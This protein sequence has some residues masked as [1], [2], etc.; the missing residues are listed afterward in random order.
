MQNGIFEGAISMK[1]KT[2]NGTGSLTV[3][4]FDSIR[5]ASVAVVT[6][7]YRLHTGSPFQAK[8]SFIDGHMYKQFDPSLDDPTEGT[9][10][11]GVSASTG[12]DIRS[13]AIDEASRFGFIH[14]SEITD[15]VSGYIR[16]KI[17]YDS[18]KA[19]NDAFQEWA[20]FKHSLKYSVSRLI[21][22]LLF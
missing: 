7:R 8:V 12:L 5:E 18:V 9:I 10:M 14:S 3:F 21:P 4:R 19:A 15:E 22:K 11:I 20:G 17:T 13:V 1:S 16:I 2:L 6:A